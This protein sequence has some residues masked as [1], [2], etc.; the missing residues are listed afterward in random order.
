VR[1]LHVSCIVKCVVLIEA[2]H[3]QGPLEAAVDPA[4]NCM[5]ATTS[6]LCTDNAACCILCLYCYRVSTP[7]AMAQRPRYSLV[8]KL[9][10]HPKQAGAALTITR[11][12]WGPV[13]KFGS[14]AANTAIT[15]ADSI[16]VHS[17]SSNSAT[18]TATAAAVTAS[19][20]T[21]ATASTAH[22]AQPQA[23]T[24]AAA[25]GTS[26]ATE[27]VDE[28]QVAVDSPPLAVPCMLQSG[29]VSIQP[30]GHKGQ[31]VFAASTT[32]AAGTWLGEYSGELLSQQQLDERYAAGSIRTEYVFEAGVGS[33]VYID[34]RD[35][36]LSSW[37][38]FVN[39]AA[40]APEC[41]VEVVCHPAGKLY[42]YVIAAFGRIVY[43][44]LKH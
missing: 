10:F 40:A 30:A 19:A 3:W 25:T 42:V 4:A 38:R 28:L 14:A 12:E 16:S 1:V 43:S 15:S 18:A 26:A 33:D 29:A 36:Q 6:L 20:A 5:E 17:S 23:G 13:T 39:H 37:H 21:V 9:V 32:I 24:A 7:S 22:T 35:P 41:N 34:A 44:L 2:S 31:G 8:W 11:D 27:P